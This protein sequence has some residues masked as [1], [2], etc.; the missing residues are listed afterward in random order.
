MQLQAEIPSGAWHFE[1]VGPRIGIWLRRLRYKLPLRKIAI[2]LAVSAAACFLTV[3]ASGY[4]VQRHKESVLHDNLA[5]LRATIREYTAD[6]H[7]APHRLLDLVQGGYLIE[8]PVDPFTEKPD[9]DPDFAEVPRSI[10][11][12]HF[13]IVDVHSRSTQRARDGRAYCEW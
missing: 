6:E 7:H 1:R 3:E 9:W 10:D 2:V 11:R 4:Q 5:L 13:G 8:L 12:E